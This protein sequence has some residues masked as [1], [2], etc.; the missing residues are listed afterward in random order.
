MNEPDG[1]TENSTSPVLDS[2]T[3]ESLRRLQEESANPEFLRQLV[4]IFKT[5]APKRLEQIRAAIL[6]RDG[7]L[8]EHAAHTLK[9]NCSMLG[10]SRMAAYCFALEGHG[11]RGEFEDARLVMERAEGEFLRVMGEVDAL[12]VG[13]RMTGTP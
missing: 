5:N 3:I 12:A 9:S 1:R 10:A 2:T 4:Q 6:A 8:L 13:R 7:R 11:E